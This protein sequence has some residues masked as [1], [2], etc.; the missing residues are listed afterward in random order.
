MYIYIV[1]LIY[2][3][4]PA[5]KNFGD[6]SC[7]DDEV[8][9]MMEARCPSSQNKNWLKGKSTGNHGVPHEVWGFPAIFPLN[10][11]SEN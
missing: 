1:I 10:Q 7:T 8:L 6:R 11:S 9:E 4:Y 5:G 3:L 2:P